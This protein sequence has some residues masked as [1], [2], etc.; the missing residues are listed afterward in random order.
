MSN[1]Y[2]TNTGDSYESDLMLFLTFLKDHQRSTDLLDLTPSLVSRFV[3]HQT[4][5]RHMSARTIQ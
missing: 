3:Q 5:H 4:L 1:T 2:S